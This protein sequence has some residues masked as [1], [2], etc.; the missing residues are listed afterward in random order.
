MRGVCCLGTGGNI[1]LFLVQ[2]Q[3]RKADA[4]KSLAAEGRG[5]TY[6]KSNNSRI[7]QS[8]IRGHNGTHC[9]LLARDGDVGV[10]RSPEKTLTERELTPAMEEGR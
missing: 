8:K 5:I 3:D 9:G 2:M 4:G 10:T 7:P 1:H 6:Y